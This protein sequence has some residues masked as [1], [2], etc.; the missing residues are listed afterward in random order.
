MNKMKKKD[1]LKTILKC[2]KDYNKFPS[3]KKNIIINSN[4]ISTGNFIK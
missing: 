4:T 2:K 1:F 3:W